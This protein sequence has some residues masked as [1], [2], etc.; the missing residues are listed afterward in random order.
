[1][2]GSSYKDV[3]LPGAAWIAPRIVIGTVLEKGRFPFPGS[4]ELPYV[5]I[6]VQRTLKGP[7]IRAGEERRVFSPIPVDVHYF[8]GFRLHQLEPGMDFLV[9]LRDDP[10]PSGF[11][12]DAAVQSFENG[13]TRADL[14][15]EVLSFLQEGPAGEFD[16]AIRLEQGRRVRFADGLEVAFLCHSHKHPKVGGTQKEWIDLGLSKDRE[17]SMVA[18]AHGVDPNLKESWETVRWRD[19]SIEYKAMDSGG[20][21]VIVVRKV[22]VE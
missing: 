16:R 14:D 5:R 20:A 17:R 12:P 2:S 7:E 13:F 22:G 11:P 18:L 15:E 3:G 6:R 10:V 4:E 8:G 19:Y 1:M 21:P 9:Y